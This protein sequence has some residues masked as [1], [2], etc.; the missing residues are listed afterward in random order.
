MITC[1]WRTSPWTR[2]ASGPAT[3]RWTLKG[4]DHLVQFAQAGSGWFKLERAGLEGTG[5]GLSS[6]VVSE[7]KLW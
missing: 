6:I 3:D 2:G 7:Q 4:D 1:P 5:A